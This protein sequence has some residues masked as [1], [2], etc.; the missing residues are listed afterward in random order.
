MSPLA[1]ALTAA[2]AWRSLADA[3]PKSLAAAPPTGLADSPSTGRLLL[4]AADPP[5]AFED[6]NERSAADAFLVAELAREVAVDSGPPAVSALS[7][8]A[9]KA[10]SVDATTVSSVE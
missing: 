5:R 3:P 7:N 2:T 10:G 4:R 6:I 1:S 8:C 9:A